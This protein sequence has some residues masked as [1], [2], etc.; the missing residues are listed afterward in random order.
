[1]R[2]LITGATGLVGSFLAERLRPEETRTLVRD[3][4]RAEPLRRLGLELAEG[5]LQDPVSLERATRG[6]DVV[7]HC[8]ARVTLPYQGN[9]AQILKTNVDGTR[10][11][12]EAS[13]RSGVKRF[14]FVSSVAVYGDVE[15]ECISEDH[16]FSPSGPYS[17]SKILAEQ[18]VREYERRHDLEVVILRPCVIYGPRDRNFLPQ[19][20]RTLPR[21]LLPL[22]DGGRQPLDMV[23][24][25]DVVEALLLAGTQ[26]AA[27]GQA[28]NVTDGERHTIR[29]LIELLTRVLPRPVRTVSVPYPLAYGLAALSYGWGRLWR[30]KEEPLISPGAVRAMARPHHYDISKIRHELGYEPRVRFEDGLR[31]ALDWYVNT[32]WDKE[33]GHG[34]V[35]QV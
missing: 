13:V 10:N 25:T 8:A 2:A 14:V 18:L 24:V 33:E 26:E 6:I 17:E 32:M 30:P 12:L 16:P 21:G 35:R 29:E 4:R 22:V 31:H 3:P 19:I 20:L 15:A 34:F 7:Y 5:D 28:Y 1:M 23:Y 27:R 11:L 9:R